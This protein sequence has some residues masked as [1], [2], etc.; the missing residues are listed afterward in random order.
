MYKLPG[1][2]KTIAISCLGLILVLSKA[3]LTYV[4]K[5]SKIY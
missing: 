3:L 5:Y 4:N 2:S 1:I